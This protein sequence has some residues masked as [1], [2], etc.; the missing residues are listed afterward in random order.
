MLITLVEL[1]K[2]DMTNLTDLAEVENLKN[3]VQGQGFSLVEFFFILYFESFYF[4]NVYFMGNFPCKVV[5]L[6]NNNKK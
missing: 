1:L 5:P 6:V 4:K 3:T 2:I